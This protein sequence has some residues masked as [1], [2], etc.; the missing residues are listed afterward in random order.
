MKFILVGD[1]KHYLDRVLVASL[2]EEGKV[3]I[4]TRFERFNADLSKQN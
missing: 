2:R 1:K 4:F 3:R